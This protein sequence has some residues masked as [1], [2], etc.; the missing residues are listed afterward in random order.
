M[1]EG[2]R[3]GKRP[4][5]LSSLQRSWIE[6]ESPRRSG[7]LYDATRHI[8]GDWLWACWGCK[9]LFSVIEEK[10]REGLRTPTPVDAAHW[11]I[12]R[13]LADDMPGLTAL[14]IAWS[15]HTRN[16]DDEPSGDMAVQ[17]YRPG[18]VPKLVWRN[19]ATYLKLIEWLYEEHVREHCRAGG[20]A[21]A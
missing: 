17:V 9:R 8:D 3:T 6:K 2:E 10:Y 19:P 15:N 14:S 7:V 12:A 1:S 5:G 20:R 4:T 16:G 21:A 18:D 11:Q 13:A